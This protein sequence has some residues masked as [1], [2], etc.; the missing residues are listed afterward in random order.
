MKQLPLLLAAVLGSVA[1]YG[2]VPSSESLDNLE[3]AAPND[4]P[5]TGLAPNAWASSGNGLNGNVDVVN[6][7][8]EAVPPKTDSSKTSNASFQITPAVIPLPTLDPI[9]SP[10]AFPG[11]ATALSLLSIAGA[12]TF[13][14]RHRSAKSQPAAARVR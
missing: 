10:K 13:W 4:V 12:A 6:Y 2:A 14:L 7:S 9:H 8:S 1:I 3:T 5:L 11:V